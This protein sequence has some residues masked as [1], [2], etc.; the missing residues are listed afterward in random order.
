[1]KSKDLEKKIIQDFEAG[2]YQELK[3][4]NKHFQKI[5]SERKTELT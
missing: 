1:M 4:K 2:K 5:A 3:G